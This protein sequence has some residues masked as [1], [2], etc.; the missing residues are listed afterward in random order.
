MLRLSSR[1]VANSFKRKANP[2][3]SA[4][5]G[6]DKYESHKFHEETEQNVRMRKRLEKM[7]ANRPENRGYS[8]NDSA[9][10]QIKVA[11]AYME[12]LEESTEIIYDQKEVV[13]YEKMR[14]TAAPSLKR[15]VG[16]ATAT[17]AAVGYFLPLPAELIQEFWYMPATIFTSM[18]LLSA[19]FTLTPR[20]LG[21]EIDRTIAGV[22]GAIRQHHNNDDTYVISFL[23]NEMFP[24]TLQKAHQK[25]GRE[26]ISKLVDV[27]S[28]YPR[29]DITVHRSQIE[30][31]HELSLQHKK[32]H[33]ITVKDVSNVLVSCRS[34]RELKEPRDFVLKMPMHP[35]MKIPQQGRLSSLIGSSFV[36]KYLTSQENAGQDKAIK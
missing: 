27:G 19:A 4:G 5:F 13:M 2:V 36:T 24:D 18:A 34:E 9:I 11:E 12:E 21:V 25:L 23:C 6:D 28:I 15:F 20:Y 1:L 7:E 26:Y 30:T 33:F 16:V 29:Y 14:R 22:V 8:Q 31:N 17:G 10:D 3:S 32:A 35:L